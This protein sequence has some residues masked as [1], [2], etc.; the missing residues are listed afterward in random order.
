MRIYHTSLIDDVVK[1]MNNIV[2]FTEEYKF[3]SDFEL[4]N[5]ILD[6]Y[7]IKKV[8]EIFNNTFNSSSWGKY[9]DNYPS[10]MDSFK[11]KS[12]NS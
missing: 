10:L 9:F 6:Q 8:N 5:K 3:D 11:I 1:Y 7:Y 12:I 2:Y 4:I